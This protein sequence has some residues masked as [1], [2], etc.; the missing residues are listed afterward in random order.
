M[1]IFIQASGVLY[2]GVGLWKKSASK[3]KPAVLAL[4]ASNGNVIWTKSLDSQPKN[5]G[6]RGLIVDNQRY[7]LIWYLHVY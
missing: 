7:A 6:V 5:G 4:D 3:Q 1:P 2:I